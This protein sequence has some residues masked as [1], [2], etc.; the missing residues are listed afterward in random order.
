MVNM[1]K[2]DWRGFNSG[3]MT[4]WHDCPSGNRSV[5]TALPLSWM[6]LTGKHL[7]LDTYFLN[8]N[9][10]PLQSNL[11]IKYSRNK[12]Q[13][14]LLFTLSCSPVAFYFNLSCNPPGWL[15]LTFSISSQC[16]RPLLS[17]KQKQNAQNTISAILTRQRI[18]KRSHTVRFD[19][20]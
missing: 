20:Y 3:H 16:T 4:G 9:S 11:K 8:A 6:C 15:A 2:G 5:P 10:K 13:L 18:A 17:L 19:Q 14:L 12:F 7:S 1:T